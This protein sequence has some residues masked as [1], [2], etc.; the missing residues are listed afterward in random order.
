MDLSALT[1]DILLDRTSRL[2][3]SERKITHLILWH[4]NEVERR[5]LY[6][7][8]GCSSMMNYLTDHLKYNDSSA[9]ERL[10][11]SRLLRKLPE[12]A[13]KLED[14]RLNL[15]QIVQVNVCINKEAKAGNA[16]SIEQTAQVFQ[17]IE[18]L[19]K[20][21]TQ[22]ALAVEFNQPIQMHEVIKPQRDDTVRL[23]LTFTESQM[24]VLKEAKE[25]LSHT[26]PHATWA[27]V[28]TYLA[29]KQVQKVK[30]K[31]VATKSHM[32]QEK[33]T[34]SFPAAGKRKSIKITTRRE[35]MANADHCCEFVDP[36]TKRRC[37]GK[38]QLQI[39]HRIPFALGGTNS[40][41]N[42]RVLCRTHNILSGQ[43]MGLIKP[44]HLAR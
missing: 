30:G 20:Y 38:F 24:A 18:S 25:T 1:N 28:I 2:V 3:Q 19:N 22:K 11:A 6:A 34:R 23:E 5:R 43:Q 13:E 12:L 39:D 41:S 37:G 29:Q 4:I 8:I 7:V 32:E 44:M 36:V 17:Q 26:L 16:V 40:P 42:L 9:Y 31:P 14:G 27:D 21:D 33:P 10:Q 15:T 35:L